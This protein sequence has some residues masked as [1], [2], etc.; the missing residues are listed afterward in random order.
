MCACVCYIREFDD[1]VMQMQK[2]ST[3][4]ILL[5]NRA[6]PLHCFINRSHDHSGWIKTLIISAMVTA[7]VMMDW[8]LMLYDSEVMIM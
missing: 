6:A 3:V 1:L 4:N 5:S 2:F 8:V 7:R